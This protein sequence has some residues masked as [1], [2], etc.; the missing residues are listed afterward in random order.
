MEEMRQDIQPRTQ[1]LMVYYTPPRVP[2]GFAPRV[3]T[4]A[5]GY[6]AS[7]KQSKLTEK[8]ETSSPRNKQKSFNKYFE[9]KA[10]LLT[11]IS[12]VQGWSLIIQWHNACIIYV[13]VCACVYV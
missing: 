12:Y 3:F 8:S 2:W 13:C 4:R 9:L 10:S 11:T 7:Q 5:L 6:E 1:A